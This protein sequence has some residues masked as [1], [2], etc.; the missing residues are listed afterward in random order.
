MEEKAI[1]EAG[2]RAGHSEDYFG[3]YRDFWW[4]RDFVELMSRRLRWRDARDVLEVGFGAGHW[5]R[6]MAPHL[7]GGTRLAAIDNDPKWVDSATTWSRAL[8][9]QGLEVTTRSGSAERIPFPDASFDFVTCQTLLIHLADPRAGIG[10]ML[11]VLKPGGLLLCVEPDNFGT[12]AAATSSRDDW[13]LEEEAAALKFN[14][15]QQRGRRALGFGD[16]SLGGMLPGMLSAAGLADIEVYLSDKA[17]PLFPPYAAPE[18]RAILQD[19]EAWFESSIDFSRDQARGLF[20]AGG[21]DPAEFE[22]HWAME[23]AG[24][25]NYRKAIRESTYHCAGGVLMYLVSGRKS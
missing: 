7:S 1:T 5:T 22:A 25:S 15:A 24:R 23:V 2:S 11:R 13:S 16:A 20:I 18:Q 9:R 17:I 8:A 14:L 6:T 3:D 21:G 4:N 12:S 10:E 19:T